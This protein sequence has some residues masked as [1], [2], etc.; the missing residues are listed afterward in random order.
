MNHEDQGYMLVLLHLQLLF[1]RHSF[2]YYTEKVDN[3]NVGLK[4]GLSGKIFLRI[5]QLLV[6]TLQDQD[7]LLSILQ[8]WYRQIITKVKRKIALLQQLLLMVNVNV[9]VKVNYHVE[10]TKVHDIYSK[11]GNVTGESRR[12][13]VAHTDTEYTS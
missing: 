2:S 10:T 5:P 11:F 9:E 1:W 12:W 13:L 4:V 8:E 3:G 6:S 7:I